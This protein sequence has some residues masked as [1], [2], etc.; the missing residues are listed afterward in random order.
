MCV[1][2]YIASE[3]EIKEIPFNDDSPAFNIKK[4]RTRT[5]HPDTFTAKHI[6]YIGSYQGCGCGFASKEIPQDVIDNARRLAKK[7][8]EFPLDYWEYF[9]WHHTPEEVEE[10]VADNQKEW[11]DTQ[12]LYDL[13]AQVAE[14]CGKAECL[15]CWSGEEGNAIHETI[16]VSLSSKNLAIDFCEAW[17]KNI[18]FNVRNE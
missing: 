18:K 15:I 8:E 17:E 11:G 2:C 9:E 1:V 13:L 16:E 6:Y 14:D 4:E 5:F 12:K 10:I 7:G 3:Q